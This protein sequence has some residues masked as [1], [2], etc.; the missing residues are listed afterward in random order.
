[1]NRYSD[2]ADVLY[3]DEVAPDA[4]PAIEGMEDIVVVDTKTGIAYTRGFSEYLEKS[5][6]IR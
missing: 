6:L 3:V 4:F 5:E 2:P 1:M